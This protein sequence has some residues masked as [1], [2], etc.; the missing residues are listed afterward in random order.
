MA[1]WV[2][3]LMISDIILSRFPNLDRRGFC[4]GSI[5]PDCNIENDDWTAFTPP[6]EVT[7]WMRG[8]RKIEA[9]ADRFFEEYAR[10]RLETAAS[11][12]EYAFLLGYYNHLLTDAADQVML[13]DE[14]RV[15]GIWKRLKMVPVLREKAGN[16]AETFDNFKRVMPKSDRLREI[17]A[18]EA[19][20]LHNNPRSGYLT[21]ILP[22][23]DFPDY[24]SFLPKGAILRKIR[25]MGTMPRPGADLSRLIGIDQE[26]YLQFV[27]DTAE[28][29][30]AKLQAK[31]LL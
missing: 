23:T 12:E 26:E 15:Q 1:T 13:R 21:E 8:S 24:L 27:Q 18:V 19:E 14:I 28:Y 5:A 29:V 9:D 25:V 7:H 17:Q 2:T 30:I 31:A 16:M 3:H 6:R 4:V 20:Y 11:K 22:L 10:P